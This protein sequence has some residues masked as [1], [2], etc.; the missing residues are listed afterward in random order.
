MPWLENLLVAKKVLVWESSILEVS[1]HLIVQTPHVKA[2]L[3]TKRGFEP[4]YC[5]PVFICIFK[6]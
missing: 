3:E 2:L 1:R 5:I 6:D 4:N